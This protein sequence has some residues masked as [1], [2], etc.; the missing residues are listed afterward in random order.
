MR[1]VRDQHIPWFVARTWVGGRAPERALKRRHNNP[2]LCPACRIAPWELPE[3]QVDEDEA[4]LEAAAEIGV[5]RAHRK[6]GTT[7]GR[8]RYEPDPE[9]A[10]APRRR[11]GPEPA[12]TRRPWSRTPAGSWQRCRSGSR[13]DRDLAVVGLGVSQGRAVSTPARVM[14]MKLSAFSTMATTNAIKVVRFRRYR[15]GSRLDCPGALRGALHGAFWRPWS[16]CEPAR[17]QLAA[18][19]RAQW[20]PTAVV[21]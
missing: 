19:S 14:M 20:R 8:G 12:A 9:Q 18:C 2:S 16:G 10:P 15:P 13:V 5:E 4:A 17:A 3:D 1:A 21:D 7:A 6:I 11:R